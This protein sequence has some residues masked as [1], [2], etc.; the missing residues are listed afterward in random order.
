MRNTDTH[1][2]LQFLHGHKWRAL[3]IIN[4]DS[5]VPRPLP[6]RKVLVLTVCTYANNSVIIF[7]KSFMHLPCPYVGRLTRKVNQG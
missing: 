3:I 1:M 6:L 4:Q 7:V 5:L 2:L